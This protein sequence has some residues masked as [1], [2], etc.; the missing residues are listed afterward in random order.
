M[1]LTGQ[2]ILLLA[3][4]G[5]Q[6]LLQD[7]ARVGPGDGPGRVPG[8]RT[9]RGRGRGRAGGGDPTQ[10]GHHQGHPKT[11]TPPKIPRQ[12]QFGGGREGALTCHPEAERRRGGREGL[13]GGSRGGFG[14][15]WVQGEPPQTLPGCRRPS[16][17]CPWGTLPAGCSRP[18]ARP[19]PPPA[20]GT[21]RLREEGGGHHIGAPPKF[22]E[23]PTHTG[24]PK[25]K[26]NFQKIGGIPPPQ[27][28]EHLLMV[29]AGDS[30]I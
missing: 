23:T 20:R 29:G 24:S 19:S 22:G 21:A 13:L 11:T 2:R 4:G 26:K 16:W 27:N 25:R 5:R 17:R 12:Q 9:L 7:P 28:N 8:G 14:G 6:R 10:L 18:S 30:S 1:S 3:A 15:L